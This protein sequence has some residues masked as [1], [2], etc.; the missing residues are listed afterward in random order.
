[1]SSWTIRTALTQARS[2]LNLRAT[3][4]R[5]TQPEK[6][7][8]Q[9]GVQQVQDALALVQADSTVLPQN[10]PIVSGALRQLASII[11]PLEQKYRFPAGELY[12]ALDLIVDCASR[13]DA[14]IAIFA[15]TLSDGL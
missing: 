15:S 12:D 11:A 3:D 5:L 8:V 7:Q 1:M 14:G 9:D 4:I 13:V 2:I 10:R 6:Q